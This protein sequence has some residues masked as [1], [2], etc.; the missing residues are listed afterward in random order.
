[1]I[2]NPLLVKAGRVFSLPGVIS[3]ITL[4]KNKSKKRLSKKNI[5]MI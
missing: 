2:E 3:F 5:Y 1:V 4:E